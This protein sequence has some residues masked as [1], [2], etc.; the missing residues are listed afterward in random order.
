MGPELIAAL[1]EVRVQIKKE[2]PVG[3]EGSL[4]LTKLDECEHWL[5]D[6]SIF[7]PGPTGPVNGLGGP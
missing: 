5:R 1:K 2:F 6:A 3:R 7:S 4:A